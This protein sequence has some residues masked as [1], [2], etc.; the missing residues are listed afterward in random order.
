MAATGTGVSIGG[1]NVRVLQVRK[2]KE[3]GWQ[4]LRGLVAPHTQA[5][6]T[7]AARLSE[8]KSAVAS[9]QAKGPALV[10]ASGR[11]LIVR[12]THVPPVPDWRLEMLM[13]FEIQEV[14]EQSGG[15][16]SAAYAQLEV[17][18]AASGDNVVL[19]AL[20]KNTYLKPRLDALRQTGLDML[21]ACPKA[22]AAYWCYRENGKVR[23][24][25][26]VL[27]LNIGHENTDVAIIRKGTLLF[28]RNVAGGSKLLTDAI[29]QNVRVDFATAEKLKITKGNLTPKGKAKY[30]DSM[31]EKIANAMAGAAGH[32]VS[33]V[34]SSVMFAKAQTKV[35][36]CSIS[37]VVVTG[38]GSLLKGLADYLESSL[39]LPVEVFDPM[40]S[41]D[42]SA[43]TAEAQAALKQDQGGMTVA[44]GL[45][46]MAADDDAFR[47]AVV[48]EEDKRKRRFKERTLFSIGAAAVLVLGLGA[49]WSM[50]S[51]AFDAATVEKAEL[52]KRK[53][54]FETN[55]S[56][57]DKAQERVAV[58]T[59]RKNE[60][61]TLV[62]LGP[63][64][65]I[66]TDAVHSVI[67]QGDGY[68][69]VNVLKCT[70]KMSDHTVKDAQDN[71]VTTRVPSVE[72]EAKIQEIGG[73]PISVVEAQFKS[74]LRLKL[75]QVGGSVGGKDAIEYQDVGSLDVQNGTFK[76]RV[77]Q[78]A[79]PEKVILE[80]QSPSD[81]AAPKKEK[82]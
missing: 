81:D 13:N 59:T 60:L 53:A 55:R 56:A 43:L 40:D 27:L 11:D 35:P 16:V 25:E 3:G 66:I 63:A 32:F 50:Q 6:P 48:P 71:A 65:Q 79:F 45:A 69:E 67:N 34:N 30:R 68:Q 2:T 54:M 49:A 64:F 44:L 4:V 58:V 42:L 12:Y 26:T 7:E 80:A 10:G 73:R 41:V 37:R 72:F 15:D 22:V 82:P 62:A 75:K 17:D 24:D 61:R 20:A 39:N 5:E 31:E 77:R 78:M 46:Q 14:A 8:A 28:G 29:Q 51:K 23:L 1:R 76:F 47:V 9:A 36:E 18:D 74:D 19:V 57:F 33:A 70:S 21:G 38:G 52:A